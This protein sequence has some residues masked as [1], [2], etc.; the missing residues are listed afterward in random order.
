MKRKARDQG[1]DAI[2]P[3]QLAT[4][5]K[6]RQDPLTAGEASESGDEEKKDISR[7]EDEGGSPHNADQASRGVPALPWMRVPLAIEGGAAVPLNAV[8]GLQPC[9]ISGM[10]DGKTLFPF[11]KPAVS[12]SPPGTNDSTS[13]VAAWSMVLR[14]P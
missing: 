4:K 10:V 12:H 11:V 5:P 3:N 7:G 6:R 13:S 8:R 1:D 2:S 9:I 14:A